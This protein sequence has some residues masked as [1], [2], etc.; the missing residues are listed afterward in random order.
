MY[1]HLAAQKKAHRSFLDDLNRLE[2]DMGK[3]GVN[4]QHI[5]AA[6]RLLVQWLIRHIR[7][8]DKEFAQFLDS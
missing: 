2:D 1:P 8:M 6:K 7:H 4:T 5:L 3:G